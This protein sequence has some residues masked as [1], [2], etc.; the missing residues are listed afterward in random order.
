MDPRAAIHSAPQR[1]WLS[2]TNDPRPADK[3]WAKGQVHLALVPRHKG[4]LRPDYSVKSQGRRTSGESGSSA[5]VKVDV[6]AASGLQVKNPSKKPKSVGSLEV[7][8]DSAAGALPAIRAKLP[9]SLLL[10]EGRSGEE[11]NAEE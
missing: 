2:T 8:S 5:E 1:S 6:T 4:L 10:E 11:N 3:G 7:F 9:Q